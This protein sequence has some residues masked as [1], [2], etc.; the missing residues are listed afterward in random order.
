MPSLVI[1]SSS[2]T[3]RTIFSFVYT[4][5]LLL[6]ETLTVHD[7]NIERGHTKDNFEKRT[8]LPLVFT[9]LDVWNF[10]FWFSVKQFLVLKYDYRNVP[11]T[12]FIS[13]YGHIDA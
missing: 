2:N 7:H 9:F 11:K 12:K 1:L 5:R 13:R 4:D 8:M 6:Y 3:H 10:Y